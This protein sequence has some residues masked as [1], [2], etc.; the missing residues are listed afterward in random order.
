[1]IDFDEVVVVLWGDVG[2]EYVVWY[3]EYGYCYVGG[4]VVIVWY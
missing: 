3:V 1:M 4:K 2:F